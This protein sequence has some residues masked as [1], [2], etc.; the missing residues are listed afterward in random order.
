MRTL[1]ASKLPKARYIYKRTSS[2]GFYRSFPYLTLL[3][4][5]FCPRLR[6]VLPLSTDLAGTFFE[7]LCQLETVE[8]TWCGDLTEVFPLD[9]D[10]K[11]YVE[12]QL[13]P[14]TLDLPKLKR[15]HLHELPMLLHICELR[16]SAPNL[17]TVKIRGCWSLRRLPVVGHGGNKVVECD[18][19]KEWWDSLE[20]E[21]G[22]HKRD[23]KPIHSRYYKKTLLRGTVLR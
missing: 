22:S 14:V 1:W 20:W 17:E 7:S 6:T 13:Q 10:T 16:L 3:H 21:D 15:I 4:Q 11:R 19:E 2:S 5:D 23:Y 12:R 8:I 9:I 18:C